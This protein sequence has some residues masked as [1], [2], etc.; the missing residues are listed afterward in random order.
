V[1]GKWCKDVSASARGVLVSGTAFASGAVLVLL[2]PFPSGAGKPVA[3]V[4]YVLVPG[5]FVLTWL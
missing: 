3:S 1:W 4:G 2:A 5:I